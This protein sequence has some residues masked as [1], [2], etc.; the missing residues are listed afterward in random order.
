MHTGPER[1]TE[2]PDYYNL[3]VD[4][5]TETVNVPVKSAW[6]STVNWASL[7]MVVVMVAKMVGAPIDEGTVNTVTN[8]G[9]ALAGLYVWF[10]NS[11]GN[12]RV[13]TSQPAPV[14]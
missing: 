11:Y 2:F 1:L 4:E 10:K 6:A 14:K 13:L 7:G 12:P 8:A 9:V 5:M 3:G